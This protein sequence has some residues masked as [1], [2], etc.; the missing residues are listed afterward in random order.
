MRESTHEGAEYV[1]DLGRTYDALG[2]PAASPF[3]NEKEFLDAIDTHLL[4]SN[5]FTVID[6]TGFTPDQVRTVG[7]Y[8]DSLP[9]HLQAKIIRIGF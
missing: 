6:M 9:G 4:K 1:D 3:W 5:D 8:L 7:S 2:D